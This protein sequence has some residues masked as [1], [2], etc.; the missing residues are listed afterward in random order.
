M[1]DNT[2]AVRAVV[3]K[4]EQLN[5]VPLRI[6]DAFDGAWW[7]QVGGK[8]TQSEL[9]MDV[10]NEGQSLDACTVA[11]LIVGPIRFVPVFSCQPF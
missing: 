2:E 11:P 8:P 9:G 5:F 10:T 4:Y 6:E 1:K 7:E 3:Q